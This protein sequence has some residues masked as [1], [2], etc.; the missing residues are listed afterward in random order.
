M[1]SQRRG[2]TLIELMIVILIISVL[3][4]ILLPALRA[5]RE[6]T[7]RTKCSHNLHQIHG[8]IILY[9]DEYHGI[10]PDCGILNH[11]PT[12]PKA[13]HNLLRHHVADADSQPGE[14]LKLFHCPS[15]G[16]EELW[17]DRFGSSYQVNS[18]EPG[19]FGAT[20]N[21]RPFN[22]RHI[23]AFPESATQ[24]L[25]R[26]ARGWHRLSKQGGWTLASTMGQ[27]VLFLDGHIDY[28]VDVDRHAA[29]IW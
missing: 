21:K 28:F 24:A 20:K 15:D 7:R 10:L 11:A 16:P 12:F 22:G 4:G 25:I 23:D 27:Q 13:L 2:F 6:V 5:V 3:V 1:M 8:A 26:D 14:R 9:A 17:R 18:D 19:T 29:G